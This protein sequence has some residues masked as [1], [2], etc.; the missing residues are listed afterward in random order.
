MAIILPCHGRDTG[1]IPVTRSSLC[2]RLAK[3]VSSF[4]WQASLSCQLKIEV[5]GWIRIELRLPV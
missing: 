2:S 3:L 4:G 5:K 1:S